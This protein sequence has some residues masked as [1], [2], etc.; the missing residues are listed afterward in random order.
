MSEQQSEIADKEGVPQAIVV[1]K[2]DT[3][4]AHQ[5]CS[6]CNNGPEANSSEDIEDFQ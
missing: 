5:H 4:P 2:D 1:P 3:L 6:V